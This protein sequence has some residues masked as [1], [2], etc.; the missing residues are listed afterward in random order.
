[1]LNKRKE[2]SGSAQ[3]IILAMIEGNMGAANVL[4][5]VGEKHGFEG[6]IDVIADLDDMNIRGTQIWIG[7]KDYCGEDLESFME[8]VCDRDKDMIQ[9][10]N[11]EMARY[12]NGGYK[13]VESGAF[14]KGAK[15]ERPQLSREEAE[16]LRNM[17]K[18]RKAQK[19][20]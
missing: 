8:S 20:I 6:L 5:Q 15:V 11:I 3:N 17:E 2:L 10:I 19:G 14:F 12:G 16:N 9:A 7:Y 18:P 1:M 4:S 13:A